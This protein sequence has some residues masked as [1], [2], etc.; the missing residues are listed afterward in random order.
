MLGFLLKQCVFGIT[1]Q[2]IA[3]KSILELKKNGL[4]GIEL[5]ISYQ[6]GIL[7]ETAPHGNR[8]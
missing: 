5:L 7:S 8:R 2:R 1:Y 3:E 6:K 4:R